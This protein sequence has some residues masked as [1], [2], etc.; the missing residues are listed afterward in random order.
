M[1]RSAHW[2]CRVRSGRW[3]TPGSP[4]GS[5][6]DIDST[7]LL[8]AEVTSQNPFTVTYKI[9]PEASVDRQRA[10]RRG[11]FL[12]PVAPDG[13]PAR[14]GRPGGLRPDHRRAVDRRRQDGGRHVLAALPG[15]AGAVQRH[16][17]RAHR[18]GRAGRLRGRA[19]ADDAGDR[20]ACSASRASIRSA[21]RSCWPATTGSGVSPPSPIRSCSAAPAR[22]P[23]WPIRSATA[24]R[25]SPRCTA[26]AAAFA[27]LSAIPEVRTAR[28]RT[29][30][31][32]CS[33]R[34]AAE[35]PAAH[36]PAGAQGAPGSARRRPAR[37][38]RCRQ[39]QHRH[40]RAGAG[41][42]TVRSR[43]RADRAAAPDPAGGAGAAR[44]A[45][46]TRS[47]PM[48]PRSRRRCR[49]RH[50]ERPPRPRRPAPH[51]PAA[52]S[53]RTANNSAW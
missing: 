20:R 28:D 13:Q 6:W 29:R 5:R 45:P 3:P 51:P 1:P 46:G 36:R 22:R 50:R 30:P 23:R 19:G 35:Q 38:G 21:T 2:C 37:R 47:T 14:S 11:R 4:T 8:S 24:T 32:S 33:C 44:R 9:K 48:S 31:A 18:Q 17:A 43:L 12:V 34:C 49:S 26:A 53:A 41:P 52:A 40:I 27:Q 39:R 7:L 16:P 15:V 42:L 10:D 25:R